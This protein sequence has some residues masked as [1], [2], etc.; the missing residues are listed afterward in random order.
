MMEWGKGKISYRASGSPGWNA[1]RD[2]DNRGLGLGRRVY[3]F[4]EI[5][6]TTIIRTVIDS[7]KGVAIV[8]G[9]RLVRIQW[10][11]SRIAINIPNI[12]L[13]EHLN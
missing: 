8:L 4:D 10:M 13:D 11:P 9:N 7:R 6:W 3:C 2:Q 1:G 12:N 5:V